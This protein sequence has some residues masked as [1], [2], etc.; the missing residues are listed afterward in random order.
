MYV[1]L[2]FY[3]VYVWVRLCEQRYISTCSRIWYKLVVVLFIEN[4]KIKS[5]QLRRRERIPALYSSATEENKPA[6]L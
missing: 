5:T 6:I 3:N 2:F 4:Q 1:C